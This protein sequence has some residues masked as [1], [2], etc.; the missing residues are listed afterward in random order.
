MGP[1]YSRRTFGAL[2]CG[3]LAAAALGAPAIAQ[4]LTKLKMVLNWRYQGPQ[5]WF[6]IAQDKGYLR[7]AGVEL[8]IDQGNGSGAA[9]GA[10]ASGSYDMGF[11]DINALMVLAGKKP[12]PD[13]STP[14]GIYMMFNRPP[15][16]IAVKADGPIKTPKDLEGKTLGG[17]ANDGALQL[18]PAFAKL[19]GVDA[20]K[21]TITNMAPN[22]REQMLQRGQVDGAFGFVNTIRFSAKLAGIDPDKQFRFI[23]YGDHGMDLYSNCLIVSR[24]LVAEKPDALKGIVR[25]F[26]RGLVDTLKDYDAAVDSVAKREPLINKAVEKERLI[27]TLQDEMGHPEIATLGLG[28]PDTARLAKSIAIVKEANALPRLPGT[29]EIF[30]DAFLP[31]MA[32]RIRKLG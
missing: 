18:F 12:A 10:V 19:A 3:S 25:A 31:P 22:L 26:N 6:F 4:T 14:I 2:A 27:A 21:V 28:A 15:F 16:T 1:I 24:K 23:N 7:E 32:E 9:V 5:S 8:E 20:S 13:P 29:D 11:G 17:P 30:N